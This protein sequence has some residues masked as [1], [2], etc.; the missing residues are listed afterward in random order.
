VLRLRTPP[1]VSIIAALLAFSSV[2]ALALGIGKSEVKSRQGHGR[3]VLS[4]GLDPLLNFIV[5]IVRYISTSL[6]G[7][8]SPPKCI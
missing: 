5:A 3:L 4:L 1:E 2:H 8:V 6:A 7:L